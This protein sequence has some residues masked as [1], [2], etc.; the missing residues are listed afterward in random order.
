MTYTYGKTAL[1]SAQATIRRQAA[2]IEYLE[3]AAA[4]HTCPAPPKPE[5]PSRR[6]QR[7]TRE[8]QRL[9]ERIKT[10][11]HAIADIKPTKPKPARPKKD[12]PGVGTMRL[13]IATQEASGWWTDRKTA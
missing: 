12:A 9:T 8:N 10:L 2:Y 1:A 5:P 4:T 11:T 13:A 3:H 6:I 7:L